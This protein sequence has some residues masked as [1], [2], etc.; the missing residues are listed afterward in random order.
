MKSNPCAS[1][2]VPDRPQNFRWGR[3]VLVIIIIISSL[4]WVWQKIRNPDTFPIRSV[5]IIGISN[6]INHETLRNTISPYLAHGMLWLNIPDLENTLNQLSWVE[7]ATLIRKWPDE[8]FIN[9]TEQ[10]P[11]AHWNNTSLLND[12]GDIFTPDVATALPNLPALY[13]PNNTQ[14]TVWGGYIAMNNI[15]RPIGLKVTAASMTVRQVWEVYL[16]NGIHLYLGR[17]DVL[18]RLGRF[19]EAYSGMASQASNIQYVDLRYTQGFAVKW[20]NNP[21]IQ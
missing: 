20:K 18:K 3:K 15:L 12:K 14:N 5:K 6:H 17:D 16:N 1:Q 9:I 4:F 13:G 10:T 21:A 7:K 8:L 2:P 11:L 19:V